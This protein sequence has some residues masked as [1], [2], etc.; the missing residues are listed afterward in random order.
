MFKASHN[1]EALVEQLG[2]R[3]A[4]VREILDSI[5][6]LTPASGTFKVV[7][8]VGG[9]MV[10]VTGAVVNGVTKVSNAWIQIP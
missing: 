5:K 8:S 10:T 1:L 4:V 6:T 7:T 2:S 9:Q 3:E